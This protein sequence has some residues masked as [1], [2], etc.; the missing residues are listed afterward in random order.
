[1]SFSP[2][3][4]F[5]SGGI[6]VVVTTVVVVATGGT[7]DDSGDNEVEIPHDEMMRARTMAEIARFT[8]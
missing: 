6:V 5:M 4:G 1:M 3:G 2:E 8:L 7:I